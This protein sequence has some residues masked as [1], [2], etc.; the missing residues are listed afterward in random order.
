M[1]VHL[2]W[3][4]GMRFE[5][6]S[7]GNSVIMD[8]KSPIGSGSAMTPKELVA[9]GLS[10]CTAMDVAALL[11]KHK[12]AY[13]SLEV[14]VEIQ[15]SN[16]G[17]PVV[18]TSALLT[19]NIRGEVESDVLLEAVKLSQTKYCGVSAMLVK[20]FPIKYVVL[21]NDVVIG[22]GISDFGGQNE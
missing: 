5:S 15:T 14:D 10:G 8:A 2:K 13:R 12:Q 4:H 21:L 3:D 7:E 18:F 16:S 22:E 20:A 11:K 17:Q 6:T 9:A 1:K 19:F